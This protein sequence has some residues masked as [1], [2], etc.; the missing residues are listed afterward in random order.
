MQH[1]LFF[2]T[3]N[4]ISSNLHFHQSDCT[5]AAHFELIFRNLKLYEFTSNDDPRLLVMFLSR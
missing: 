2:S 3:E 4:G 5:P 1:D